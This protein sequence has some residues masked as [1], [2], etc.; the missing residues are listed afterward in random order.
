MNAEYEQAIHKVQ[1]QMAN[2][3]RGL[4]S[5]IIQEAQI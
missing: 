4:A 3:Y 5:V 2:N 1:I